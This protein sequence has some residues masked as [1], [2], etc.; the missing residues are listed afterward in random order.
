MASLS[1]SRPAGVHPDLPDVLH[2]LTRVHRCPCVAPHVLPVLLSSSPFPRLST[3]PS[4]RSVITFPPYHMATRIV[5]Y[6][7]PPTSPNPIAKSRIP[8]SIS[9]RIVNS[10]INSSVGKA[11]HPLSMDCPTSGVNVAHV[12][13]HGKTPNVCTLHTYMGVFP[14]AL[15]NRLARI[16]PMPT[17]IAT[18]RGRTRFLVSTPLTHHPIAF[19]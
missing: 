14:D 12:C 16:F 9:P 7:S 3:Q 8:F 1:V 6:P 4:H 5:N 18:P 15:R 17:S 19:S 2:V 13:M 10:K 11:A